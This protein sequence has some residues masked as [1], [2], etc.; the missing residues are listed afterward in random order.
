MLL[1]FPFQ[2]GYYLVYPF[3]ALGP[4]ALSSS[5]HRQNIDIH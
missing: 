4:T 5:F 3:L 1:H 2:S